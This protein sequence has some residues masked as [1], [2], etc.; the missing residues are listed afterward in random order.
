MI[1]TFMRLAQPDADIIRRLQH[2]LCCRLVR[3]VP[4]PQR[5]RQS[6]G[7]TQDDEWPVVQQTAPQPPVTLEQRCSQLSCH[8]A[9]ISA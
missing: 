7:V 2:P 5:K 4:A 6:T 8:L 3:L 9:A 1:A